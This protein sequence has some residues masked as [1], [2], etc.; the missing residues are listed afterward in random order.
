MTKPV[1]AVRGER[2]HSILLLAVMAGLVGMPLMWSMPGEVNKAFTSTDSEA[3]ALIT[4]LA[5]DYLPW[6]E[7]WW[8]PPG[9]AVEGFLFAL[10]VV[11]GAGGVGYCL[12]RYH[13]SYGFWCPGISQHG[14]M[15]SSISGESFTNVSG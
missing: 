14:R 15:E 11:L 2:E 5:P 6:V 1:I 13:N 4:T 12:G 7:V 9:Q 10:Q 3:I 8:Q